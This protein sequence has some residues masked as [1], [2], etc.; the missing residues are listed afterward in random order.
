MPSPLLPRACSAALVGVS[1]CAVAA[2]QTY[3]HK[4][5]RVVTSS[6]GGGN[7]LATRIIAQALAPALGQPVVVDNRQ[8]DIPG[9]LVKQA[10]PDGYTLLVAGSS[11][12]LLPYLRTQV[13]F[14]PIRD[15]APITLAVRSPNVIVV[16]PALPVSS[17]ADLIALAKAKPGVLNYAS[18][19]TGSSNHLAAELFKSMAQVDIVR[20]AYKGS[21]PALVATVSNEVQLMFGN[22]GAVMPHVRAR[23]LKAI[24]V[25]TAERTALAPDLPTVSSTGLPGYEATTMYGVFGPAHTPA[26]VIERLNREIASVL[27]RTDIKERFLTAGVETVGSTPQQLTTAMRSEMSTL[28]RLIVD[29]GIRDE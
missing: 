29:T 6:I 14:D 16:H 23:R 3:P 11:H 26:G 27:R 10:A 2:E 20:I 17:T 8:N 4:P 7:D 22:T 25:T 18:G 21:A 12:W 24:A 1:L 28:G 9:E 15:Y 13:P 5:I 19:S